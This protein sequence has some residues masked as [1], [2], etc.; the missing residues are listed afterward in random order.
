MHSSG[1]SERS[2]TTVMQEQESLMTPRDGGKPRTGRWDV[3]SLPSLRRRRVYEWLPVLNVECPIRLDCPENDLRTDTT[4]ALRRA[5]RGEYALS[6]IMRPRGTA[7][8]R[9]RYRTERE[10][11]AGGQANNEGRVRRATRRRQFKLGCIS[12]ALGRTI[13]KGPSARDRGP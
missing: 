1:T 11:A 3:G 6:I 2:G 12:G 10:V 5:G 13:P 9:V 4:S 7:Q 8:Q